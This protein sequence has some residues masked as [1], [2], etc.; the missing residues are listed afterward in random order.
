VPIRRQVSRATLCSKHSLCCCCGLEGLGHSSGPNPNQKNSR[1]LATK[2]LAL[3]DEEDSVDQE[4]PAA[5][6]S[7]ASGL[8]SWHWER[9][10]ERCTRFNGNSRAG[11]VALTRHRMPHPWQLHGSSQPTRSSLQRAP[12][13]QI[14]SLPIPPINLPP[15]PRPQMQSAILSSNHL[16]RNDE[17]QRFISCHPLDKKFRGPGFVSGRDFSR[18]TK[19]SHRLTLVIPNRAEA[20]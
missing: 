13:Q 12:P 11:P 14:P 16:I 19:P 15:T 18:A 3:N 1:I 17:P 20:R 6:S 2:I 7:Q 10:E 5:A 9:Q 4:K 8:A